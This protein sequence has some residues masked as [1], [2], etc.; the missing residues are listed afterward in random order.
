MTA[1]E[2]RAKLKTDHDRRAFLAANSTRRGRATT[3][4]LMQVFAD[5]CEHAQAL[6]LATY[7]RRADLEL[8]CSLRHRYAFAD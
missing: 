3:S 5:A 7:V 1:D 8:T 6:A 4:K 2:Y